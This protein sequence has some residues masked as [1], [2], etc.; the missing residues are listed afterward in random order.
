MDEIRCGLV[1]LP[2]MIAIL[3]ALVT[4]GAGLVLGIAHLTS[5]RPRNAAS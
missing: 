4:L 3:G 2:M 1:E 5:K